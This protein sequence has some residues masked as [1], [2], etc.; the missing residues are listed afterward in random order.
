MCAALYLRDRG[1]DPAHRICERAIGVGHKERGCVASCQHRRVLRQRARALL[2]AAKVDDH[3][4]LA[5]LYRTADL[6]AERGN[7]DLLPDRVGC[8][9]LDAVR[10]HLLCQIARA[11][12]GGH[13]VQV[14]ER[15]GLPSLGQSEGIIQGNL[16]LAAA[17]PPGDDRDLR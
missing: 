6:R 10:C 14:D 2:I 17:E 13:D 7:V 1:C 16:G 5:L 9:D 8:D 3:G 15:G 12:V 11:E 4:T